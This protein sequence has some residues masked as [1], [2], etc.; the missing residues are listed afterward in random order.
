MLQADIVIRSAV[1]GCAGNEILNPA[2]PIL[3][4][5]IKLVRRRAIHVPS[6]LRLLKLANSKR[7]ERGRDCFEYDLKQNLASAEGVSGT[8]YR[9]YGLSLCKTCTKDCS[10]RSP[11]QWNRWNSWARTDDR[12]VVH[13][14]SKIINPARALDVVLVGPTSRAADD[15]VDDDEEED[16]ERIGPIF[17]AMHAERICAAH[18]S[19]E[20][21]QKEALE[22]AIE[23][24]IGEEGSDA[25]EDFD[26]ASLDLVELYETAESDLRAWVANRNRKKRE[27]KNSRREDSLA[28]KKEKLEPIVAALGKTLADVPLKEYALDYSWSSHS[29]AEPIRF[30]YFF[31]R[32]TMSHLISAPSSASTKRI[33]STISAVRRKLGILH[34]NGD[35]FLSFSFLTTLIEGSQGRI[36][37]ALEKIKDRVQGRYGISYYS[38]GKQWL[39]DSQQYAGAKHDLNNTNDVFFDLLEKKEYLSAL[40]HILIARNDLVTVVGQTLV[41]SS[42]SDQYNHR[43]LARTVWKKQ[44]SERL[45]D[46]GGGYSLE[47][48]T[49]ALEECREEFRVMKTNAKDYLELEPVKEF[50]ALG[51]SWGG[52]TGKSAT[53]NC[54]TPKTTVVNC[55]YPR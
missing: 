33:K 28:K 23:G 3:T 12:I 1:H 54:W 6:A 30:R 52:L 40:I 39:I 53:E 44:H 10:R 32:D 36:K 31:M 4:N 48:F 21:K 5:I 17:T 26:K 13:S 27:E 46:S 49:E 50:S 41:S 47:T 55:R 19:D 16:F 24:V 22:A 43:N 9:A 45:E 15:D 2:R 18:P 11:W 8:H 42:S 20:E 25:W 34:A 37:K 51:T 35:D 14:W 29:V 38:S 7:C